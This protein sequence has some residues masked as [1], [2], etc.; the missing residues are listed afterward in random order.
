MDGKNY[1]RIKR[2]NQTI[3]LHVDFNTTKV[4]EVMSKLAFINKKSPTSFRLL[5]D[6]TPLREDDLLA[7]YNIKNDDVLFLVYRIGTD[8]PAQY[9]QPD[10]QFSAPNFG[11]SQSGVMS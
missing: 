2:R 9:E 1:I 5:Y 3:F 11:A 4:H 10:I 6:S 7:A 8:E